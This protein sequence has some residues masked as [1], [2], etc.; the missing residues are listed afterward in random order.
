MSLSLFIQFLF[1]HV[2]KLVLVEQMQIIEEVVPHEVRA[3]E[4][5]QRSSPLSGFSVFIS[6]LCQ[7]PRNTEL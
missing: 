1:V 5:E 7:R 6:L 4:L 2:Q 3:V